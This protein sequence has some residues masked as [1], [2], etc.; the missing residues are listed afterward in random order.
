MKFLKYFLGFVFVLALIFI[1][2][3]F[4]KPSITYSSEV[5]VNKSIKEA[6]A[7][8]NDESKISQWLKGITNIEHISGKKGTVGAVTK[9]T[10]NDNGQES[11]IL[12]TIKEIKPNESMS[13]SFIM[14]KVMNMDYKVEFK[15]V[16]GKTKITSSTTTKGE[17]MFMKSMIPFLK[18]TM[19]TQEDENMNNLKKLIDENT[20]DYFPVT[21]LEVAE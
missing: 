8:M 6:Q 14:E 5:S 20:T 21:N 7:V 16:D 2:I 12:E 19:Q 18:G 13:M 11:I 4:I 3:G 15:N 1:S 10:F 9:Y 17:G